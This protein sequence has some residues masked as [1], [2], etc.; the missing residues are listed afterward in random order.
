MAQITLKTRLQTVGLTGTQL[1]ITKPVRYSLINERELVNHASEDSGIPKAMMRA[2]F[3]A[4]ML[5]V[6]ELLLNGHSI[7]LGNLGNLRFSI[8]C[9]SCED[10][11]DI[12]VNNVKSRR[13]IFTPSSEMKAEIK[14]V[15]F[16]LDAPAQEKQ[17]EEENGD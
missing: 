17:E 15:K 3:D 1:Y 9:K 13:I 10:P 7:Q 6:R 2:A 14:K 4:I 5:Q 12:S 11:K 16:Y 8:R